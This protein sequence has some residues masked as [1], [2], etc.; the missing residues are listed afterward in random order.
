MGNGIYEEWVYV[1]APSAR[2]A[3]T[4]PANAGEEN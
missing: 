2:F 4:S 3:G 1:R